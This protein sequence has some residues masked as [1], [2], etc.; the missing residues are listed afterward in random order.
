[1]KKPVSVQDSIIFALL[2]VQ[3]TAVPALTQW[4]NQIL[5]QCN[6]LGIRLTRLPDLVPYPAKRP[7]QAITT[8]DTGGGH[9]V[10]AYCHVTTVQ[11]GRTVL[12]HNVP[13]DH[14]GLSPCR[15]FFT[16]LERALRADAKRYCGAGTLFL[17]YEIR[18]V[19]VSN[20]AVQVKVY[21]WRCTGTEKVSANDPQIPR[22]LP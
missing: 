17:P 4:A 1:M 10:W 3:S 6:P 14:T 22:D 5:T 12:R 2:Y 7:L 11:D 13:L 8:V 20:R 15:L 21:Q 9:D 18:T 16:R 19:D